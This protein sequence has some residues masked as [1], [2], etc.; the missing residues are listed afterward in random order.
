VTSNNSAIATITDNA[1]VAGGTTHMF[2]NVSGN[3][4]GTI[5]V[6]G[7]SVGSTTLTMQAPAYT[8]GTANVTVHPSG[9]I[10]NA[11]SFS[12]TTFSPNTTV[13][14][15]PARLH[16]TTLNWQETQALRGG[17]MVKV[18]V[19]SPISAVG[20]ITA[21]QLTFNG[22]DVSATTE[23]DPQNPGTTTI[24]VGTPAGFSTPSNFQ[25]I[26]A[27][28]TAPAITVSEVRVG[29][30]L[31]AV[32]DIYLQ[33][34]PPSPVTVTVTSNDAATATITTTQT[35]AGGTTLTFN[36]VS[37]T[38]V[39]SLYVQGRA[40]G[41]TTL[42]VQATGYTDG[43][44]QV[45]VDPSGFVTTTPGNFSTTAS[46]PNTTIPITPARLHPTTLNWQE[47]QALRGGL[48]VSV[49]VTSSDALVGTITTSPTTFNGGDSLANTAFAPVAAGA[50]TITVATPAGFD[51]PSNYRSI[52][53]T[54]T[55]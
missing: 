7:R 13:Q 24:S 50:A 46:S 32:L 12:T 20:S 40:L 45:T 38:F 30:D 18:A 51:T 41:S 2:P 29:R 11:G 34:V 28:V 15:T 9:F 55:P 31:Q 8:N 10:I 14:I 42:T 43:T 16:P 36:G 23:F 5:Y 4:V 44:G 27:T 37:G 26:T 48:S 35:A 49:A 21:S 54:V 39:G 33:E 47:S 22:G 3:F 6:Q 1:T 52:T 25:Q 19:A 53:A 17:L